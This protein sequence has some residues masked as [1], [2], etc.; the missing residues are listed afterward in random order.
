MAWVPCERM[1]RCAVDAL[2]P[3]RSLAPSGSFTQMVNGSA[4]ATGGVTVGADLGIGRDA[5]HDVGGAGGSTV[6]EGGGWGRLAPAWVL[7]R[8]LTGPGPPQ[9]PPPPRAPTRNWRA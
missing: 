8:G 6:G 2:A 4:G 9:P 1:A 7:W 3:A 5:G